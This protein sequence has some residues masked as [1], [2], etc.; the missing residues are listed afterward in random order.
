MSFIL[1]VAEKF[2]LKPNYKNV[3]TIII[4]LRKIKNKMSD[5]YKYFVRLSL[6]VC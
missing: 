6:Q 3:Q 2:V 1:C 5:D 4:L